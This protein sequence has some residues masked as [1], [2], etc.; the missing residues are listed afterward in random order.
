MSSYL[1]QVDGADLPS[2]LAVAFSFV[3]GNGAADHVTDQTSS[4]DETLS[5]LDRLIAG[6]E[7]TSRDLKCRFDGCATEIRKES[8]ALTV[9][10]GPTHY[11][12]CMQDVE[13]PE[14]TGHKMKLGLGRHRDPKRYLQCGMGVTVLPYTEDG[15]VLLGMRSGSDYGGRWNGLAG[16]LPFRRNVADLDPV[17]HARLEC[18]EELG[19]GGRQLETLEFLGVVSFKNSLETD[20]V[21]CA[22]I[23]GA[24]AEAVVKGQTWKRAQDAHEHENFD[25]FFPQEALS[26]DQSLMPSAEFGLRALEARRKNRHD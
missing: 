16:W 19:A 4:F 3:A 8:V 1:T 20:I 2:H 25:L 5:K 12:A 24:L 15:R 26:G 18:V 14:Q 22:H 6:H 13:Q 9:R 21:F 10:V 17:A 11:Y 7:I 23:P